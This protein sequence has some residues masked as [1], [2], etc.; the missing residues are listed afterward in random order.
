MRSILP[1]PPTQLKQTSD[2]LLG[3]IIDE[4]HDSGPIPF[5]R[6][7]ER[8]LYEPG[9]GYY[10][11]G[12]Y[13]FGAEG[14]FVTAPQLGSVFAKCLASQ[15]SQAAAELG[16]YEVLE[17]GA[18]TGKL[19]VDLLDAL[20]VDARPR[21][22]SFLERSADL[23]R[24]QQL[25]VTQSG[26]DTEIRFEWLD[27]PPDRS[28]QGVLLAN[29][30]IDALPVERFE[31]R[32]GSI[33]R[34][35]VAESQGQLD[36]AL[37]AAPDSLTGTVTRVAG[38]DRPLPEGYRSEICTMLAPW[39][40]ALTGRMER[41]C[42][43]FIDYG[44]PRDIYYA[45][46]RSDGTLICNYRHRAHDDPFFYPGLQ[47]ISAF[48]DFTAVAEAADH[49]GLT[50]AGYTSQSSF[51]LDCD[52]EQVLAGMEHMQDRQRIELA[53]EVRRLTLPTEMG[54]K[55][56]CM[57]LSRNLESE[58]RGFRSQDLRFRL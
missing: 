4:I 54:E 58:P 2:Q 29:E 25:A 15:L 10:S 11:A 18:G 42:A 34:L 45:P 16:A 53:N 39:L 21:R 14:D 12:L 13:K 38:Q 41:G 57:F 7:M 9:L 8:A 44:Y 40:N 43:L 49:C 3:L 37:E 17:V 27:A 32:D 1:E 31:L 22:F 30:V 56:Q 47:D 50:V 52:L 48:V 28:W 24:Q 51:L 35:C 6:F 55:F 26:L 5:S 20:D 19:A 23:R 36:W 46:E 33:Q